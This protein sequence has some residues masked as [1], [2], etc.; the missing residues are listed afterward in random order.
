M[1]RRLLRM[2]LLML[3]LSLVRLL[4][5]PA[6]RLNLRQVL[7]QQS[8]HVAI[9]R[10]PVR[11][12]RHLRVTRRHI[13]IGRVGHGLVFHRHQAQLAEVHFKLVADRRKVLILLLLRLGLH[14]QRQNVVHDLTESVQLLRGF[15]RIPR[16][17]Q[18]R[19]EFL[20]NF[21]IICRRSLDDVA[22]KNKEWRKRRQQEIPKR[23]EQKC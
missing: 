12:L 6:I 13:G 14:V 1:R 15:R 23:K 18:R 3:L 4:L 2:L 17:S 8:H 11:N 20:E 19:Y 9:A 21:Q 5:H 16:Q 22:K 7:L 10:E